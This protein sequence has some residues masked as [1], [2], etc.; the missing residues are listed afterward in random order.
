MIGLDFLSKKK[1]TSKYLQNLAMCCLTGL[2]QRIFNCDDIQN[3]IFTPHIVLCI[4][5]Y[6]SPFYIMLLGN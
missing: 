6:G 4:L 2:M 5:M 3:N 1:Q